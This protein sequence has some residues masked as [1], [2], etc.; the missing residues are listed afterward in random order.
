MTVKKTKAKTVQ[1]RWSGDGAATREDRSFS[2]VLKTKSTERIVPEA[3]NRFEAGRRLYAKQATAAAEAEL[4]LL[5]KER[6]RHEEE[7]ACPGLSSG[8]L[9]R[10][11]AAV[12]ADIAAGRATLDAIEHAV[13]PE[14]NGWTVIGR[15]LRRDGAVPENAEVLFLADRNEPV[16]ELGMHKLGADGMVRT[17]YPAEVI[18]RIIE[19]RLRVIAGVRIG[20]RI[21]A[22]DGTP[23]H[24]GPGRV[25]LF[26]LRTETALDDP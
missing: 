23:V 22:T 21:V 10:L 18:K 11:M 5:V 19:Q 16:K 9:D 17:T 8:R 6:K 24:V 1:G 26:D 12:E 14:P 13:A 7:D 25:Y 20:G 3:V 2:Q 15:V 4:Q